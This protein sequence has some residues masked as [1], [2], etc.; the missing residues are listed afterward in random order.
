MNTVGKTCLQR[1]RGTGLGKRA[2]EA[3]N[4]LKR[5][6]LPLVEFFSKEL[7][8]NISQYPTQCW[9]GGHKGMYQWWYSPNPE[10]KDP[11]PKYYEFHASMSDSSGVTT[12][13]IINDDR[14]SIRWADPLSIGNFDNYVPTVPVQVRIIKQVYN[15]YS[16]MT[17]LTSD[18]V[19]V[20]LPLSIKTIKFGQFLQIM[21]FLE[22][23]LF[24]TWLG[25][26][27]KYHHGNIILIH[28]KK[29]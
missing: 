1:S 16:Y 4:F 13:Y 15:R 29:F 3:I 10:M 6:S 20:F 19:P 26:I 11:E 14:K 23:M 25:E 27:S 21:I 9:T 8:L 22:R 12:V 2:V 24:K 18:I 5:C 7:E 17:S 28:S